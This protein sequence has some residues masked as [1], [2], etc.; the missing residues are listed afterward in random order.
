MSWLQRSVYSHPTESS[1][2]V[3][4]RNGKMMW[5][6]ILIRSTNKTRSEFEHTQF[7]DSSMLACTWISMSAIHAYIIIFLPGF[8]FAS[9]ACLIFLHPSERLEGP[10][11]VCSIL[12]GTSS[13]MYAWQVGVCLLVGGV[14]D[15]LP[16]SWMSAYLFDSWIKAM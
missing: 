11:A 15:S 14:H 12:S 10:K 6:V 13:R 4:R 8:L 2:I 1:S 5:V 7:C 3:M 9:S 16:G